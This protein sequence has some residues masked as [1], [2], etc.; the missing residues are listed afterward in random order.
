MSKYTDFKAQ[1]LG[2][3]FD[4]DGAYGAQ[5]FD[6][7]AQY[8]KFLGV[9]Y[10]NCTTSGYVKDIWNNRHSNGILNYFDEVT[11]MEPGDIA[12]FKEAP[13]TPYSHIAIFDSDID[14]VN[15][16]FLGQN[17]GGAA[18]PGGGA[19]FNITT[20]PYSATFDTAFR[21][22]A[23][24]KT[25]NTTKGANALP[26]K[27]VNGDTYSSL[28]T[29]ANPN[30]M[31]SSATPGVTGYGRLP[32]DTIVIHHNAHTNK[33][34][35]MNTWTVANG[36]W[37][38]AH[39]EITPTE[40][41]GCVG[42]QYSAFH[43]GD[44]T[45][46]R[47]SIGLEHV[48]ETGAPNWTV[49][50]AT[51][52]NSAKLIADICK[53]YGFKPDAQHIIP[54]KSVSSTACPGGLDMNKLIRYAQEAY[55]GTPAKKSAKP[56]GSLKVETTNFKDKAFAVRLSNVKS[57]DGIKNV[58]FAIWTEKNGQDDLK[59]HDAVKQKDGTWLLVDSAKNHKNELGLYN[60][61]AYITTPDG[62]K[63]GVGT[64][65][66]SLTPVVTG[67]I[68][69][70]LVGDT[71]FTASLSEVKSPVSVTSVKFPVWTDEGGQDDIRWYTTN[72]NVDGTWSV[73]VP[74]KNHKK[75]KGVYNV[76][77]YAVL[78]TGAQVGVTTGKIDLK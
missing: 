62:A 61:H 14:G 51:L 18:Y 15:G 65:T 59:W 8:C 74:I 60:I 12:V 30:V 24:P 58:Q 73:Q 78:E 6:G 54:H 67:K 53:R 7:Y 20:L 25:T 47:R 69:F 28:I 45:M 38:S 5:C 35:A 56:S 44:S 2:K 75:A 19:V 46:N 42:E 13:A 17:Q 40:I 55:N 39:Y 31:Y 57:P 32:I 72:K 9:P 64:A 3:G 11:E 43:S 50:D 76:H 34:V 77:A 41:I 16:R 27:N 10:A 1:V 66:T 48:N 23:T 4:L 71:A 26:T 29:S 63:H 52:R 22:K 49:A 36:K 68:S 37:T 21:L 70:D 33:D